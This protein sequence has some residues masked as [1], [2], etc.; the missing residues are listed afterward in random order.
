[1]FSSSL[2]LL[3]QLIE[4]FESTLLRTNQWRHHTNDNAGSFLDLVIA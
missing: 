3:R 1:M 2:E 4:I